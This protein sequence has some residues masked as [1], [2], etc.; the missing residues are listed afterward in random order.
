MA[1]FL[2]APRER[3]R[4]VVLA[5]VREGGGVRP[6]HREVVRPPHVDRPGAVRI[7][8]QVALALQRP[9]LVVHRRGGRQPDR[10]ADLPDAR[11]VA[12]ALHPVAD[13][14]Q[15]LA[16]PRRQPAALRR[17]VGERAD[18]GRA[19]VHRAALG[20][21]VGPA[22]LVA[23]HVVAPPRPG[24]RPPVCRPASTGPPPPAN[25]HGAHRSTAETVALLTDS[26]KHMF[27]RHAVFSRFCRW[28]VVHIAAAPLE[29]VF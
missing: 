1:R 9:Q 17:G 26:S 3:A 29:H 5:H 18:R 14:L 7:A 8:P 13:D 12:E 22:A 21:A 2:R 20:A 11:R 6:V 27:E 28:A 19:V 4:G 10:V 24:P 16:L 15:H 25:A 23:C